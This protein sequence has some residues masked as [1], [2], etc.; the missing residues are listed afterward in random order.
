VLR[1]L[2]PGVA[3]PT[4]SPMPTSMPVLE[5]PRL[6]VRPFVIDDLERVHALLDAAWDEQTPLAER[7]KWL[8]WT[9]AGYE[10]LASLNQPPYGDRAVV[11]RETGE[12]AGVTGLV[13]SLGPF[14][15]LPSFGGAVDDPASR[16]F[17]P[18]A[19]LY[20]A[21]DPAHQG[22]GIATEAAGALI[23]WAFEHLSLL[24]VVATTTYDNERSIAVMR[25]LGM[26]IERNPLPE[27]EWFQVAGVL[28]NPAV[29]G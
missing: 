1:P 26:R 25:K 4:L 3:A 2:R 19:G 8:R 9:V 6:V 27:P 7:E 10:A 21:V 22:R 18:Q 11:L 16:L 24:R 29:R 20:W 23:A 28:D 13:P 5:T 12:L 15:L 17:T 14:G